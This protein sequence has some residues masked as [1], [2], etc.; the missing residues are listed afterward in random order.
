MDMLNAYLESDLEEEIY[1][2]IPKNMD[3]LD[4]K[5]KVFLVQKDL[6]SFKQSGQIWSQKFRKYLIFISFI[7]I[8]SDNCVFFNLETDI[9]ISVYIDNLLI[10][11]NQISCI[12]KVKIQLNKEY[13]MKDLGEVDH[14]LRI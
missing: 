2:E 8:L 1:M 9:F 6:Y 4:K 14:I 7:P 11:S 5:N 3:I 13:K 10:F 12:D